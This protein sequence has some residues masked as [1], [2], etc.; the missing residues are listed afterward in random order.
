MQKQI[1]RNT[2][3]S[4]GAAGL[5]KQ[6][7][8]SGSQGRPETGRSHVKDM[9]GLRVTPL[10]MYVP[11]LGTPQVPTACKHVLHSQGA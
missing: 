11:S 2:T 9:A 7:L 6:E 4:T 3:E 1:M 8:G 5:E 10:E